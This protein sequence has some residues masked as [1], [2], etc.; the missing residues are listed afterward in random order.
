M[1][2]IP[3]VFLLCWTHEVRKVTSKLSTTLSDT[4]FTNTAEPGL[5]STQAS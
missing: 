1:Q 3:P 5:K 4:R 2:I